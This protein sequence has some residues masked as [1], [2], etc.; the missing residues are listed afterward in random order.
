[1]CLK[2]PLGA[3]ISEK[4]PF[5]RPRIS[6]CLVLHFRP[7]LFAMDENDPFRNVP[8]RKPLNTITRS[9]S[10]PT[11]NAKPRHGNKPS[12]LRN[13]NTFNVLDSPSTKKRRKRKSKSSTPSS[14]LTP[15]LP[16]TPTEDESGHP[17]REKEDQSEHV[18]PPPPLTQTTTATTAT[19]E[20]E[21]R[22]FSFW[23]YLRDEV[24][25]S[26]FD[27]AQEI[28]RERVTNFLGVPAAVEKVL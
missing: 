10:L 12:P 22:S 3:N 18:T 9:S 11:P 15:T 24:T 7:T 26:D 14:P 8:A 25:V 4:G 21:R 28:K 13:N 2:R 23:D 5:D 17:D 27:T 20:D 19:T 6:S 1:M 16:M